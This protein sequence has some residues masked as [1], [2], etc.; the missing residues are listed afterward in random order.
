MLA[1][2]MLEQIGDAGTIE[3]GPQPKLRLV[4]NEWAFDGNVQLVRATLEFPAV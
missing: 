1:Y 2:L 3:R 4:G